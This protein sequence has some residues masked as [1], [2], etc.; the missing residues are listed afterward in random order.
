MALILCHSPKGGTGNT[1]VAAHVAQT[2]A[3]RGAEV[4]LL[5]TATFDPLPL[6]FAL[7]PSTQLPSLLA[8]ADQAVVVGGIDLR[9]MPRAEVDPDFSAM[10][11][12]GGFLEEG[13]ERVLVL[14]VP[15][16][17]LRFAASLIELAHIHLCTLNAAPECLSMMPRLIGG[18]DGV[19]SPSSLIVLNALDETRRLARHSSAFVR[20]LAGSQ[21]LG[22]VRMDEAVAEAAAMLQ[23]L[24]RYAPASAALADIQHVAGL[25]SQRLVSAGMA[26]T[27]ADLLTAEPKSKV[28]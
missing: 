3:S 10:I 23:P 2:L 25:V 8:P 5:T 22:R 27:Q 24:S 18:E 4:T 19:W 12:D 20:E 28:A 16:G 9:K 14:D 21:L 13:G 11:R 26:I 15:S 7:P 17:Q 1:F 6:H